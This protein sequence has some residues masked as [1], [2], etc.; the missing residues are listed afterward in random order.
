MLTE[1]IIHNP[2]L[3]KLSNEG[4]VL[5]YT[6]SYLLVHKVPY[7]T[8]ERKI[9]R[10]IL[11]THLHQ[12]GDRTLK[13]NNH[14]AYFIG[15][16]PCN[17]DGTIITAIKNDSGP[18]KITDQITADLTFSGKADDADYYEKVTRYV[19]ILTAP[20]QAID[21]TVTAKTREFIEP[22]DENSPFWYAD[23]NTSKAVIIPIS[24]KLE[25]QKIAIIG[26]GGTGSYVLDLVA[27]T[28][29]AAI[30][31]FD[32][33]IFLQHNAFRAPGA[34]GKEKFFE[35]LLKTEYYH[36]IYSNMHKHIYPHPYYINNGN[37][38]ELKEM[39]FIFICID[40]GVIKD[41][42]FTLL[43]QCK[44]PFIDT[45]LGVQDIDGSLKG[46]VR[47]T[48]S[49]V[50]KR[51]HIRKRVSIAEVGENIYDKNIQIA[52]LNSLNAALAV[53]KWKK[54]FGFYNDLDHEH[55]TSYVIYTNETTNEDFSV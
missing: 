31:I 28:P 33:D 7:V 3:K 37:I 27:K 20:A 22:I 29:V 46:Q 38:N 19:N 16:Q 25:G 35:Q 50:Q 9:K 13:P 36:T 23:T 2:D 12:S 49:T 5:Q 34:A 39:D 51:D 10:G 26:M 21:E 24:K 8:S 4:Y 15:E 55:Y 48:T 42:I 45:G 30:H 44:I 40:S 53:I 47:V 52:D 17:K 43:E 14:V 11:I 41:E 54:L 18:L 6:H 32:G 1:L